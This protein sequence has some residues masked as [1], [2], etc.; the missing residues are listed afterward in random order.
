MTQ[1][2]TTYLRIRRANG[3]AIV[4]FLTP[5]LQ[6]E[7]VITNVGAELFKLVEEEGFTKILLS[8]DGVRFVSS[9]MLAE[10]IKLH[11]ALSKSKG[12][13]RLCSLDPTV[14][15][16]LRVSQLDRLLEVFDDEA[17]ALNKF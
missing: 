1:E 5:Y 14:R 16:V 17:A 9:A 10:V 7:E 8:F 13:L 2:P 4:S 11:K 15:E 3:V 12:R 6:T